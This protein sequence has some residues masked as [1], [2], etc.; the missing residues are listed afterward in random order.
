MAQSDAVSRLFRTVFRHTRR[1]QAVVI[2]CFVESR[3]AEG[4]C[5]DL[6]R[7]CLQYKQMLVWPRL[8]AGPYRVTMREEAPLADTW[9]AEASLMGSF[10][11]ALSGELI[12]AMTGVQAGHLAPWLILEEIA[13]IVSGGLTGW[14]LGA[15]VKR[16][17]RHHSSTARVVIFVR[18]GP[19]QDEVSG[20]L[21][22]HGAH[23]IIEPALG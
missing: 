8:G 4:A 20:I 18:A 1:E 2:G 5:A 17:A 9:A 21:R 22:R 13:G 19:R 6:R 23:D 14:K 7:V 10:L 15:L 16:H 11:G 12:M 3:R